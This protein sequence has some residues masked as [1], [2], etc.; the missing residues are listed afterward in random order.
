MNYPVVNVIKGEVKTEEFELCYGDIIETE[1]GTF[2]QVVCDGYGQYIFVNAKS[3]FVETA[4]DGDVYKVDC[5]VKY[6]IGDNILSGKYKIARVYSCKDE[7][8]T[9][10]IN[11]K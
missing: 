10:Q 5:R 4:K 6:N 3:F 11:L 8:V 9:Y 2:L 1:G 7:E